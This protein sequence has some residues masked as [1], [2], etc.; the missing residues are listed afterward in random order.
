MVSEKSR[1]LVIASGCFVGVVGA[2]AAGIGFAIFSL[3][4]IVGALLQPRFKTVGLGLMCAGS[5]WL[6]FWVFLIAGLFLI[7]PDTVAGFRAIFLL[8]VSTL[9]M[10]MSDVTLAK[11]YLRTRKMRKATNQ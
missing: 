9:L 7:H 4:Q 2:L 10:I 6:S 3:P 1:W 5:L 8:A 11:E